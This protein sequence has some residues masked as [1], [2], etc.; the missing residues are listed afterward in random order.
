MSDEDDL[1]PLVRAKLRVLKHLPE[2][3]DESLIVLKG[4]LLIEEL[5]FTIVSRSS[6][7]PAALEDARLSFFNLACVAK[8]LVFEERTSYLWEAIFALNAL[9]NVYAHNLEPRTRERH[10]RNFGI[11]MARGDPKGGEEAVARP[12]DSLV[13]GISLVCGMLAA[14]HDP[15]RNG[16]AA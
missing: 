13:M 8:A 2:E 5:L 1:H 3:G 4:H 16:S 7:L 15:P 6:A 12:A 9:R 14:F 10:L 11:A